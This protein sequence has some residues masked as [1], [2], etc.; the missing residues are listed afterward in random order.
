MPTPITKAIATVHATDNQIPTV[1][2]VFFFK[3]S[4]HLPPI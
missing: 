3:V 4:Y 2:K 1:K